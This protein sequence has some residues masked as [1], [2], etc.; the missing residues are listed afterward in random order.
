MLFRL[1]ASR[2]SRLIVLV[3]GL[4]LC[5]CSD[6]SKENEPALRTLDEVI[7]AAGNTGSETERYSLLSGLL[8]RPELEP[9]FRSDLDQLLRAVDRWANGRE[10]YWVPGDQDLAG[11]GG[12]LGGF[13][14]LK[15]WPFD[16]GYPH[17]VDE[18]SPL[19]AIRALYRGRMLIWNALEMGIMEELCY[20]DG[21]ALLS[22]ALE[23]FPDNPVIP[24]YLGELL[25]WPDLYQRQETAPQ[26]ATLQREAL[27]K[28]REVI[29]FWISERQAID[30]QFGGGWGDDVEMWRHWTPILL[31]FDEPEM[32]E[33]Q[34]S[35]SEGLFALP[36]LE[37]GYTNI[38]IDVEHSA[39]DT[40]DTITSMLHLFPQDSIW[41]SRALKL[42]DLMENLW[43]D[44]NQRGFR[45]FKSTY[46][47]GTEVD[48]SGA[49][50]CDTPYHARAVQPLFL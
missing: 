20:E 38:L 35:L 26:W 18:D 16:D 30:G 10:K 14:V 45:Q 9:S 21:R 6:D 44:I 31:G 33:A 28:L 22:T 8:D 24:M 13:F 15:V 27:G 1:Q 29:E 3:L 17:Q 7:L 12:Y 39:E 49:F 23:A 11:E 41:K 37:G 50:A 40:G 32:A 42:G 48:L 4:G 19:Y 36:R 2:C 34:R 47:T 5:T 43:T 25:L 46:F